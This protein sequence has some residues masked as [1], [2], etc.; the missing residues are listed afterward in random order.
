MSR[1]LDQGL[2]AS[3]PTKTPESLRPER[4]SHDLA[5]ATARR[6]GRAFGSRRLR[7]RSDRGP[8]AEPPARTT[9]QELFHG[10]DEG[11][12][13]GPIRA[14]PPPW[15]PSRP[16]LNEVSWLPTALGPPAVAAREDSAGGPVAISREILNPA[17]IA[18]R[19]VVEDLC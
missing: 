10:A 1:P 19:P 16:P 8:R 6:P 13:R 5:A 18:S 17:L 9:S 2:R 14:V 12:R 4:L 3:I 11:P 15:S 7:Q